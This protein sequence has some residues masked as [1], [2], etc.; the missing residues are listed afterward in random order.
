MLPFHFKLS[1]FVVAPA[2]YKVRVSGGQKRIDP[3]TGILTPIAT[4][5]TLIVAFFGRILAGCYSNLT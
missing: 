2:L 1:F 4:R 5:T 3:T